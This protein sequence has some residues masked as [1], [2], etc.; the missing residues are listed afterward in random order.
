MRLHYTGGVDIREQIRLLVLRIE[1]YEGFERNERSK[2]RKVQSCWGQRLVEKQTKF[3]NQFPEKKGKAGPSFC[4]YPVPV[5]LCVVGA[6]SPLA[7][8]EEEEE[9]VIRDSRIIK[10]LS[11][12]HTHNFAPTSYSSTRWTGRGADNCFLG[13]YS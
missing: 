10:T 3:K 7:K 2:G 9:G 6:R 4:I 5:A 11:D 1:G 13:T 12:A 8:A